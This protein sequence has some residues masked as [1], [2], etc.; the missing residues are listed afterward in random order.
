MNASVTVQVREVPDVL[1]APIQTVYA[2]QGRKFCLVQR[3]DE[4]GDS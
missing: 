3:G 1:L 2:V 4:L